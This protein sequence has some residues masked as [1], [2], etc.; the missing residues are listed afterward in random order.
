MEHTDTEILHMPP[1]TPAHIRHTSRALSN[2]DDLTPALHRVLPRSITAEMYLWQQE[3]ERWAWKSKKKKGLRWRERPFGHT[4]TH[5][6]YQVIWSSGAF[7]VCSREA[8]DRATVHRCLSAVQEAHV[9]C[10]VFF[11]CSSNPSDTNTPHKPNARLVFL[12]STVLLCYQLRKHG[13]EQRQPLI[14]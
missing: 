1:V 5:T 10:D 12:S 6:H 8:A 7:D 2:L 9:C 13:A 14:W 11:I 3:G 4:H